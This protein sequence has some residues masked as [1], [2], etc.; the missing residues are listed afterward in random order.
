MFR[1]PASEESE[2]RSLAAHCGREKSQSFVS[3][4]WGL[5]A[6]E[7]F[8]SL[9]GAALRPGRWDRLG[10]IAAGTGLAPLLQVVP[11][12]MT[13]AAWRITLTAAAQG[14][15]S[16]LMEGHHPTLGLQTRQAPFPRF[17]Q[18][19]NEHPKLFLTDLA[20][21]SECGRIWNCPGL[22]LVLACR[23]E[24]EIL[25][26]EAGKRQAVCISCA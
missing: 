19:G 11:A 22:S 15:G 4:L 21:G 13:E 17:C 14:T 24:S 7:S 18:P 9:C 20:A 12:P 2:A 1:R 3:R 26:R 25:M 10:L 5:G 8:S 6:Q 16:A 23:S